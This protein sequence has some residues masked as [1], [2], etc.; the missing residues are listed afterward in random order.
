FCSGW[1]GTHVSTQFASSLGGSCVTRTTRLGVHLSLPL[2]LGTLGRIR[3]SPG[4]ILKRSDRP[5]SFALNGCWPLAALRY[6][7]LVCQTL[8]DVSSPVLVCAHDGRALLNTLRPA[9]PT[10]GNVSAR[11]PA[12][13][14]PG[15]AVLT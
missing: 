15:A 6:C 4:S 13:R 3:D 7:C 12:S 11:A 8:G 14:A 10:P 5:R 2:S 9:L 1:S